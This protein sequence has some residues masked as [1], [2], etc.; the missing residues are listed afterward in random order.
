MKLNYKILIL[1]LVIFLYFWTSRSDAQVRRLTIDSA[2]NLSLEKNRDLQVSKLENDKSS[3]KIR[4]AKSYILPTVNLTGQYYHFFQRQVSFLPGSF[5]GLGENQL[6]PIRV[7]G[8]NSFLSSVNLAQPIYAPS[9]TSGVRAA[10]W[11]E[12]ITEKENARLKAQVITDVKKAYLDVLI[13]QEQLKLQKQS[14]SRNEVALKDSRSLLAQGR[15]SRIDTLRAFVTLENLKPEVIRLTNGI[16]IAKTVLKRTIGLDEKEELDLVDS[17]SD[18]KLAELVSEEVAFSEAIDRRPEIEG[19][20]LQEKLN[21]E[22]VNQQ[23][24]NHLPNLSL[25]GS[26]QSQAQA[27]NLEINN[28]KWPVTSYVGLQLNVP[29]LAGFRTVSKV[30]QAKI[31]R[32]QTEKQ[33]ENQKEII[34]S[35]VK[36]SLSQV[37]ESR[38]RIEVQKQTVQTAE[39][40]YRITHDRWK[41]G[42]SSRL[43]LTDAELSLTASK[44]NYLQAVYDYLVA[45][46]NLERVLGRTG[47]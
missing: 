25:V 39:L 35:E 36:V 2:V 38:R 31:T 42:I 30:K 34:R 21:R 32:I 40:G 9:V 27:N 7:G 6:A 47:N 5:I 20:K 18:S 4:E 8:E 19:L 28:Y 17:L 26:L 10:R 37:E 23:F 15:A 44:S 16:E 24:T 46:I 33:L 14:I 1:L 13:T 22:Q 12:K 43:E 11:G 3:E 45:N 41:Q 29:V